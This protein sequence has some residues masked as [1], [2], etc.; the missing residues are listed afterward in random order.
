MLT[1]QLCHAEVILIR[2]SH[3]GRINWYSGRVSP[4]GRRRRVVRVCARGQQPRWRVTARATVFYVWFRRCFHQRLRLFLLY[5]VVWSK[6]N[7]DNFHFWA[8]IK[9]H[10]KSYALIPILGIPAPL[11]ADRCWRLST[12]TQYLTWFGKSPTSTGE[13]H[14]IRDIDKGL[15]HTWRRRITSLK[16]YSHCSHTAAQGSRAAALGSPSLSFLVSH[17]LHSL[18]AYL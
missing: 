2:V 3:V 10:F 9:H 7:F 18:G 8:K 1:S 5:T 4:S 14:I 16:L 17:I 11:C 6:H 15:Q 13:V 12:L